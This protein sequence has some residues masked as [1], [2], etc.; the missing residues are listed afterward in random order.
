MER[1][2][3]EAVFQTVAPKSR[4][5]DRVAEEIQR[6]IASGQL[7]PGTRLPPERE[8]AEQL[9]VSRPVVREAVHLLIAKG[10]LESKH[11]SG[12][13]VREMTRDAVAEPLGWLA[14]SKGAT[15]DHLHQVRSIL[16]GAI[17]RMAADQA[18][19][20]EIAEL[21]RIV[22]EMKAHKENVEA[23]VALDADFHQA[24]AETTH[25][26][27]LVVLLDSVRDLMQEVRLEVHRH[28]VVY[29]TIVP[30]HEKIIA[31]MATRDPDAA[32]QAMQGHLDHAHN[33]QKEFLALRD[34][35]K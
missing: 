8:F 18:S 13:T 35:A 9:G 21:Q 10:L 15:L 16:E 6:L 1:T 17:V 3:N 28:P 12:T 22:A 26:P 34:G 11:G 2:Y 23:F 20:E 33:F 29:D 5:V 19:D 25:N 31:A 27:L 32:T 24:L 4:L 7:A 14:Q 30:D